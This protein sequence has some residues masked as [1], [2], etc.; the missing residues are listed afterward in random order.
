M[1]NTWQISISTFSNTHRII[2]F[3]SDTKI[4]KKNE[5]HFEIPYIFKCEATNR[6][7]TLLELFLGIFSNVSAFLGFS[8]KLLLWIL[9]SN[10]SETVN[11]FTNYTFSWFN[12]YLDDPYL[13]KNNNNNSAIYHRIHN[14]LIL[15]FLTASLKKIS[16]HGCVK[17]VQIRSFFWSIVFGFGMNTEIYP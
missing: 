8:L 6:Q 10:I 14:F 7:S 2:K 1:L 9:V 11:G 3:P 4:I 16:I 12:L 17:S 15:R 5:P 13:K